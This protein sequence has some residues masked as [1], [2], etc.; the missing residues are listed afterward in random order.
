[1]LSLFSSLILLKT[2]VASRVSASK[3]FT[4][5][6]RN[7]LYFLTAFHFTVLVLIVKFLVFFC[8]TKYGKYLSW[9]VC[10]KL[11]VIIIFKKV[12]VYEHLKLKFFRRTRIYLCEEKF[13]LYEIVFFKMD[14]KL[15]LTQITLQS[16]RACLNKMFD[17]NTINKS[18]RRWLI[19]YA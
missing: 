15:I 19:I 16:S 8:E 12:S 3:V 14:S 4:L 18:F 10:I 11:K 2:Q 6:Y 17:L 1:M 9:V 13:P 7:S 5:Q